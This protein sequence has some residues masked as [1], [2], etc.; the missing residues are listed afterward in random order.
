MRIIKRNGKE[1]IFEKA[2]ITNAISKA[3]AEIHSDD[4]KLTDT[5]ISRFQ[6]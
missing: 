1:V 2:K 4:L 3:N 6:G 5:E